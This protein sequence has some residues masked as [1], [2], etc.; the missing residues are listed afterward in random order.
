MM[1]ILFFIKKQIRV[2]KY[3]LSINNIVKNVKLMSIFIF[4]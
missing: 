1:N 2:N 3:F 4:P